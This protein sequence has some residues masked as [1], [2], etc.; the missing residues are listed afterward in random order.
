MS[1][2]RLCQNFVQNTLFIILTAFTVVVFVTI[3]VAVSQ[4]NF[5]A[6]SRNLLENLLGSFCAT[7]G[8]LI[9]QLFGQLLGNTQA[10]FGT[11]WLA[12]I[13][14]ALYAFGSILFSWKRI[15][16]FCPEG[17]DG[18]IPRALRLSIMSAGQEQVWCR[19]AHVWFSRLRAQ[20]PLGVPCVFEVPHFWSALLLSLRWLFC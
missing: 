5:L 18:G 15:V 7:V 17:M 8:K 14:V 2:K 19:C 10:A 9:G 13:G 11:L 20:Y 12:L 16:F 1:Q 3:S 4:A 6:T